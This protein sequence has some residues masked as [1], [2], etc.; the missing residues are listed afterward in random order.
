MLN[1]EDADIVRCGAKSFGICS[2]PYRLIPVYIKRSVFL[3]YGEVNTDNG[4]VLDI[5]TELMLF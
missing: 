5:S 1:K 4:N 2:N 3:K